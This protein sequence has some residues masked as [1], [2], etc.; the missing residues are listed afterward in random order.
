MLKYYQQNLVDKKSQRHCV[1]RKLCYYTIGNTCRLEITEA[2]WI[3]LK[4]GN[5]V[6]NFQVLAQRMLAAKNLTHAKGGCVTAGLLKILPMYMMVMI[7]MIS[8]TV[9]PGM[10][11]ISIYFFT[12]IH[13]NILARFGSVC[14]GWWM[15]EI[16]RHC[17]RLLQYCLSKVSLGNYAH[18]TQRYT[19]RPWVL[20]CFKT[21]AKLCCDLSNRFA[22][23]CYV[24][25]TDVITDVSF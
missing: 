20:K 17:C 2:S 22:S 8:R 5:Y 11:L 21:S 10:W 14:Y 23:G 19:L 7:G 16:L 18:R 3:W 6:G 15:Q 4:N 1:L 12:V 25:R 9:F 24:G 13:R